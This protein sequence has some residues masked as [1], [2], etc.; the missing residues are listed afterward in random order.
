MEERPEFVYD[1]EDGYCGTN[2][3]EFKF[4]LMIFADDICFPHKGSERATGWDVCASEDIYLR[5]GDYFKIPLGFRVLA[6]EGWW[7]ELRP[8]SS[9]FIKKHLH[10]LYGV[11]D[12][13]YEGQ[14]CYCVQFMPDDRNA[15]D[16]IHISAGEA[17]GQIIP[18]KRQDMTVTKI[19]NEEYD[20]LCQERN[21]ARGAGGF[22]STTEEKKDK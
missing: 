21:C 7:L 4:A 2:V 9:S 15:S 16:I 11:I 5:R 13:D 19:S 22:G 18:V 10:S 17:I 12:E 14:C 6:P 1:N 8:R 20:K 3:P